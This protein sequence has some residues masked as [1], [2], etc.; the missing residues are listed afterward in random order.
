MVVCE[1]SIAGG[2]KEVALAAVAVLHAVLHAHAAPGGAV[3]DVMWKR[4]VRAL[5]VGVA[6]ATSPTCQVPL[7]AS[8]LGCSFCPCSGW[9]GW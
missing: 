9:R 5:D 3:S 4:A 6:A 1:S 8:T 2:R 7:T